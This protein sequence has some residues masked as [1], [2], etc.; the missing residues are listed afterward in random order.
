MWGFCGS[1]F[2]LYCKLCSGIVPWD[3]LCLIAIRLLP[4]LPAISFRNWWQNCKCAFIS[5]SLGCYTKFIICE[6]C[7]DCRWRALVGMVRNLRV[8]KMRG[9]YWLAVEPVSFSRRTLLHGGS[10]EVCLTRN[11]WNV[12]I[13]AT[14]YTALHPSWQQCSYLCLFTAFLFNSQVWILY[15]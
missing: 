6:I 13:L 4:D 9:I 1:S 10:K 2:V 11:L 12:G 14:E 8:P 3:I 5:W 7:S 15:V